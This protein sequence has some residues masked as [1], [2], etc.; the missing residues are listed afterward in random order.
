MQPGSCTKSVVR[1]APPLPPE[2]SHRGLCVLGES[3]V[4]NRGKVKGGRAGGLNEG[5]AGWKPSQSL[6]NGGAGLHPGEV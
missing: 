2:S 5:E 1:L 3:G 6:R 4:A